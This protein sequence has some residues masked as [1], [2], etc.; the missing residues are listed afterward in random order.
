MLIGRPLP[1]ENT[2]SYNLS[3]SLVITSDGDSYFGRQ[4]QFLFTFFVRLAGG[5]SCTGGL[6]VSSAYS[7][8]M[9][10]TSNTGNATAYHNASAAAVGPRALGDGPVHGFC[11][12]AAAASRE[13]LFWSDHKFF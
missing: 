5:R 10:Q 3:S 1:P 12:M 2:N 13:S 6:F 4:P 7:C 9:Q 8:S 11:V